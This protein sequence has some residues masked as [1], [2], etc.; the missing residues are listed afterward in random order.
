VEAL[1]PW[2]GG[3]VSGVDS[4][5]RGQNRV[6]R[7]INGYSFETLD[8]RLSTLDS[9]KRKLWEH[10]AGRRR[11]G[12]DLKAKAGPAVPVGLILSLSRERI[13]AAVRKLGDE[14]TI[15][16]GISRLPRFYRNGQKD[17]G[18]LE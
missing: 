12:G 6:W 9:R 15:Q 13:A 10:I 3:Q 16:S 4:G 11:K 7:C 8:S 14:R 18:I 17:Y 2:T 1:G 5:T